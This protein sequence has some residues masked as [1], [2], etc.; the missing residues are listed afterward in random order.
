[1]EVEYAQELLDEGFAVAAVNYRLS[2]E[3]LYPAG[4]QDVKAAV[5]HL[6]ANADE[7]NINPDMVAAWG[8][9][10]GGYLASMLGATG[11]QETL[12]DDPA[13]GNAEQSSAVQ[14]V[15]SWFG[16]SDFT[17]MD[18]QAAD[19]T[20]CTGNSQAHGS[21]DSP[22]SAWLGE[23]VNTSDMAASTDLTSYVA[24]AGSLP[25]WYLAHG[26]ADCNV[27]SG[28]SAE[29][30]SALNAAGATSVLV[31]LE[32]AGHNDPAFDATQLTPT[33]NF[34]KKTFAMD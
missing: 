27:P 33:V 11:D 19:V 4:A 15:V 34:L 24:T 18:E 14:A 26:D 16:P 8:Q 29:L 17:T 7:Y 1:M 30:K 13:L 23:A 3:A 21:G 28:Q 6:R 32:G 2:A 22:E 20:A 10:A 25:A 12:F 5:R 31:E 9:S